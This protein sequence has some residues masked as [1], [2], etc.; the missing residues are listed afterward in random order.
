MT[1]CEREEMFSK[2]VLT[3]KDVQQLMCMDYTT[4]S[5][6]ILRVKR[7]VGDRLRVSG[8]LHVQDYLDYIGVDV[9]RYSRQPKNNEVVLEKIGNIKRMLA[10]KEGN[11]DAGK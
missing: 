9:D 10:D 11:G 1:F 8:K 3:I 2:D 4:A 7:K 5:Q 6:F